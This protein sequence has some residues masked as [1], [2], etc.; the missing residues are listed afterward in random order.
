MAFR[1][2]RSARLGG[3]SDRRRDF[4]S[5]T[6]SLPPTPSPRLARS[7][8]A[9]G[10]PALVLP[11]SPSAGAKSSRGGSSRSDALA[12]NAAE[13]APKG[14]EPA[15]SED[16]GYSPSADG[17]SEDEELAEQL[18]ELEELTAHLARRDRGENARPPTG[19]SESTT[20]PASCL[21]VTSVDE[22]PVTADAPDAAE[23][24]WDLQGAPR[25]HQEMAQLRLPH[26]C[27]L[28]TSQASFAQ[29]FYTIDV[30]EGPFT[31]A[32]LTFWVKIFQEYPLP[33]SVSVRCTKRVFHPS[34]DAQTGAVAIPGQPELG[35]ATELKLSSL[36]SALTTLVKAPASV[37]SPLNPEAATLLAADPEEFRRAVRLAMNG[38][39]VNAQRY[40]KVVGPKAAA[41]PVKVA[42]VSE[43]MRLDL[44]NL[45]VMK[46][47]FKATAAAY[48]ENNR[49]ELRV[50][51]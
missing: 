45:E 44:M 42:A 28:E 15:R 8:P 31:P 41:A 49:A 32:S 24:S 35:D 37:P 43:K 51:R 4:G 20:A 38:G 5:R 25:A 14:E 9:P 10:L 2:A 16:A 34:I 29:L 7:A 6:N 21:T 39:E 11:R 40:D 48:L 3:P 36:L 23:D 47:D 22:D 27:R 33:G 26:G 1:S 17:E 19:G 46:E 12:Q 50:L 30:A 13:A 18:L